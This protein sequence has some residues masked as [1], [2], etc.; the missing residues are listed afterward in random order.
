MVK[1]IA[2]TDRVRSLVARAYGD[3][4]FDFDS[5]AVFEAV[6]VNTRPLLRK[7]G[8]FAKAVIGEDVITQ[9]KAHLDAGNSVP[10]QTM[11][12][13]GIPKGR[14]FAGEA[15]RAQD[16]SLALH[17]LFYLPMGAGESELI[18][19]L[20]AGV[21][22]EVS[23]GMESKHI[24]CSAC[25]FDYMGAEATIEN[26]FECRCANGHQLGQNGVHARLHGLDRWLEL[27][28]V[29]RGAADGATILPRAKQTF[30]LDEAAGFDRT[31]LRLFAS[32]DV[33]DQ[34]NT[35]Q[36]NTQKMDELVQLK[37]DLK[38]A[39]RELELAKKETEVVRA[40]LVSVQAKLADAEKKVGELTIPD[41][42]KT[43]AELVEA[44]KVLDELAQAALMATGQEPKLPAT[45]GEKTELVRAAR[46]K[47]ALTIPAGG[48]SRPSTA[49]GGGAAPP[50][51]HAAFKTRAR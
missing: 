18:R 35:E 48:A 50:T 28:L 1:Q 42:D 29:D 32:A 45:L 6:A 12:R 36:R 46:A 24:L 43:R 15:R 38:L 17:A 44:T 20:D 27:S 8:L 31:A 34:P 26:V 16:G 4:T 39:Q 9:M 40:E 41:L 7:S 10:L 22:S 13:D 30:K 21:I 49:T 25:N 47:L 33:P 5:L 14:V 51:S 11:H 23:I 3:D 19:K 2:K 37:V